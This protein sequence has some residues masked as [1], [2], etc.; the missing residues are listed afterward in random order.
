MSTIKLISELALE[1][2]K[3]RTPHNARLLMRE[4]ATKLRLLHNKC[5][6]LSLMLSTE[7]GLNGLDE[8]SDR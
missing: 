7:L 8:S 3:G 4:A 6:R 2:E 5:E 1:A